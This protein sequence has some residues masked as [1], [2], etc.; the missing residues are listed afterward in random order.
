MCLI[1]KL[2]RNID[3]KK[4]GRS[5]PKLAVFQEKQKPANNKEGAGEKQQPAG[6]KKKIK[7]RPYTF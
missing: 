3:R 2:F 4:P 1:Q 5:T 6:E 7:C